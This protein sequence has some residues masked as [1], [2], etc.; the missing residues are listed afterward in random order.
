MRMRIENEGE[1]GFIAIPLTRQAQAAAI[2]VEPADTALGLVDPLHIP[3][4]LVFSP[5]VPG[6]PDV[7]TLLAA[8]ARVAEE[9]Q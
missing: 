3:K 9:G 1:R 6:L 8:F 7:E 2:G 5:L 4:T